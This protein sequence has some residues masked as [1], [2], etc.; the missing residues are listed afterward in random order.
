MLAHV[1]LHGF[2]AFGLVLNKMV[3]GLETSVEAKG[4]PVRAAGFNNKAVD[5]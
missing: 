2:D 1:R 4:H 5:F 3:L